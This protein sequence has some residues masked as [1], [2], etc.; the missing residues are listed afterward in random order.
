M[1]SEDD[2]LGDQGGS[3]SQG[4]FIPAESTFP[5]GEIL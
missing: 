5:N 2:S 3:Y 4:K 1:S